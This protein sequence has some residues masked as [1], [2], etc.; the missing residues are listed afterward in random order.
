MKSVLKLLAGALALSGLAHGQSATQSVTLSAGW[1]SV[2]LEVEPVD[3]G[4]NPL[5][6]GAVFTN[7]AIQM[8]AS[9]KPLAGLAEFFSEDPGSISTFNQD[10]WQQWKR[11]DPSGGN[12][13]PVIEGNRAYLIQVAPGTANFTLTLTGK[14]RFFRPTWNP[15]RY[16]LV[17]F[18]L[19]GTPT[20]DQFFG[21]SGAKH[22]VS[23]IFTLNSATGNW[24]KVTG[25]ASMVSGRAYWVY[26]SGPS[27]Y[28]GP[29]A[30]GFDGAGTGRLGFG[31]PSDAVSVGSGVDELELDLEEIVFTN[32][33]TTSVSPELDLISRSDTGLA[34]HVVRPAADSLSYLR[35]NQVDSSPGAGASASLGET[36]A[37]QKTATLSIGALRS[38]PDD[39]PRTNLYRLSTSA[40]GA[41]FWLPVTAVR[42]EI[43][44]TSG[45]VA[46]TPASEV[47][48]LW[49]GEVIANSVTSIVEDGAPSRP[50]SGTAPLR[51][52]LHSDAGG[53]VRLLSSVTLMQ[54]KSADPEVPTERVLV[55]DPARIPFFEGIKERNGKKV[56]VRLD[57]IAYDMPRKLDGESQQN[58][59]YDPKFLLLTNLSTSL[60]TAL[61]KDPSIR[62]AADNTLIANSSSAINSAKS[63]IPTLLPGYL[64]S[65]SI[66]PSKLAE[67][68]RLSID[69]SGSVG[70]G[71]TVTATVNL[72]PFHRSNPF[73]HAYHQN[74]PKGPDVN[75]TMS[76]TFAAEQGVADRLTGTFTETIRG[77][78]KSDITLSGSLELRRISSVA[79]LEGAP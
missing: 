22:S 30:V 48:G 71:Q 24:Q 46:G 11:V 50:S 62:S 13:L 41:S 12:D 61:A 51:V 37:T 59:I 55:V 76:F 52:I 31:G 29:V 72:D 43:Q 67:A 68:Y 3:G 77:L 33:G 79:T 34:L 17:G 14:A 7:P 35:G 2:W 18:G 4:G 19:Q 70:A 15:D 39:A 1:N 28:M 44:Q 9:P 53:Q 27:S 8:A 45:I 40:T 20:F 49:V 78:I 16:N 63:T 54:T 5:A 64:N 58:L 10:E 73:R 42:S 23:K 21:P 26:C 25:S 32:L 75:R 36:I 66:R 6:P 38:W 60:Q 57:S 65:S 74:L 69:A 47:T 56:G